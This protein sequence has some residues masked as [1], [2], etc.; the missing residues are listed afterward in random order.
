MAIGTVLVVEYGTL[1]DAAGV[2]DP[3]PPD[4]EASAP[5]W[6]YVSLPIPG[7]NGRVA[8]VAVGKCVGGSSAVNGQFFDRGSK[9]DFNDWAAVSSPEFDHNQHKWNWEGIQ[10]F[11]KKVSMAGASLSLYIYILSNLTS[12]CYSR[13]SR[14]SQRRGARLYLG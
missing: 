12:E 9:F 11:F 7:M 8:T 4:G 3:P 14:S 1:G 2:F 6:N 5:T 10:P 13:H